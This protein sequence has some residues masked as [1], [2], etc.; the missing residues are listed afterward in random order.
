MN[1]LASSFFETY[2]VTSHSACQRSFGDA[3][4]A[5]LAEKIASEKRARNARVFMFLSG[6]LVS[7]SRMGEYM[8][9]H[10][11]FILFGLNVIAYL[12]RVIDLIKPYLCKHVAKKIVQIFF[13]T[14]LET[15]K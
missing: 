14:L 3:A 4:E 9:S 15:V 10:R 6:F 13:I 1:T 5:P 7:V 12:R 11:L 2:H 8:T